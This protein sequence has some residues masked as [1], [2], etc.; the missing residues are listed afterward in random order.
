MDQIQNPPTVTGNGFKR[1][2]NVMADR[3]I[4]DCRLGRK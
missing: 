4:N 2:I 1:D 3:E